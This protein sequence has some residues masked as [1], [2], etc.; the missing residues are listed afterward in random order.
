MVDENCGQKESCQGDNSRGASRDTVAS[1]AKRM[2]GIE[3]SISELKEQVEESHQHLEELGSNFA[4]L[5]ED[6]KSALN[7]LG[8][9]LGRE[10]HDLR[11]ILM[12]EITRMRGEVEEELGSFRRELKDLKADL[13]LCKRFIASGEGNTGNIAP[14]VE[15]HKLSPFMGKR[16]RLGRTHRHYGGDVNMEISNEH[17]AKNRLR[18]LRHSGTIQEYVKEFTTL[19]LEI[20]DLSDQDSLSL[21]YFLDGLQ[22]WAK[23]E[24]ERR[25]VQDLA[26]A[27]KHAKALIDLGEWRSRKP[28]NEDS[29]DEQGGG[30]KQVKD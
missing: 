26:T 11:N 6:F 4:E 16:E 9:N 22:G 1:L 3:T 12:G 21:F 17:E 27:I 5:R 18:K 15:V 20:L 13:S 7:V 23:T 2:V 29:G 30:E 14:K 8:G 28:T 19:V 25:G 24:L 10:I